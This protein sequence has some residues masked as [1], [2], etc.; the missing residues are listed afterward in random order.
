MIDLCLAGCPHH[1]YVDDILLDPLW[2]FR[3]ILS[4][5]I[6]SLLHESVD[7]VDGIAE[8]LDGRYMLSVSKAAVAVDST[9]GGGLVTT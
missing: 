1:A 5:P 9:L 4:K 3:I 7:I 2:I 6:E 8:E